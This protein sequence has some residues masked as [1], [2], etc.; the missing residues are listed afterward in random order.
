M[1]AA[2]KCVGLVLTT[3]GLAWNELIRLNVNGIRIKSL[4]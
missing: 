4:E 1:L 2:F 3:A